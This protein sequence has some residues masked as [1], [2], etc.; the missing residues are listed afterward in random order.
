MIYYFS[1]Y[2]FCVSLTG[3]EFSSAF[4]KSVKAHVASLIRGGKTINA[5]YLQKDANR[6]KQIER[7]VWTWMYKCNESV[8]VMNVWVW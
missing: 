5:Q 6:E 1:F 2:H 4:S 7:E 3:G 8:T